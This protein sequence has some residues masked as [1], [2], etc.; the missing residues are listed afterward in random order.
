[1]FDCYATGMLS[2][3]IIPVHDSDK[4]HISM[5]ACNFYICIY[6]L[7]F[8][9]VSGGIHLQNINVWKGL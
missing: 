3:D 1:M 5:G 9:F 8:V 2:Y 4:L 7:P 6:F